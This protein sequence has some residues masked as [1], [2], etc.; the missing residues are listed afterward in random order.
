METRPPKEPPTPAF[1][2]S[3]AA[4]S[5]GAREP[6]VGCHEGVVLPGR[7]VFALGFDFT[8]RLRIADRIFEVTMDLALGERVHRVGDGD[9][10]LKLDL[11]RGGCP[12]PELEIVRG[13]EGERLTHVAGIV[14]HKHWLVR[15]HG[16]K[17][18]VGNVPGAKH[19]PDARHGLGGRQ[20]H[21]DE[22]R[23]RMR[24]AERVSPQHAVLVQVGSVFELAPHLR[25]RIRPLP[26]RA[27]ADSIGVGENRL[28]IRSIVRHGSPPRL[29]SQQ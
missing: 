21:V 9:Q 8:L 17:T 4:A 16:A 23:V 13:D 7:V 10:R 22:A 11:D 29:E 18:I 26:A 19:G 12:A 24:R 6:C 5:V 20:I 2:T 15:R 3:N 27:D 28:R 1:R 14:V 25:M